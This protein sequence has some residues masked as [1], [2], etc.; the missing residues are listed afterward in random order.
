MALRYSDSDD[1]DFRKL[2][3]LYRLCRAPGVGHCGIAN[4]G[5]GVPVSSHTC[6]QALRET[7]NARNDVQAVSKKDSICP[8]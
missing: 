5:P 1:P 4:T 3:R 2:Q 7:S 6:S 8:R